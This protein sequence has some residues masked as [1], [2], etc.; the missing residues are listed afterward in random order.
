[1][2]AIGS[3]HLYKKQKEIGRNINIF[4]TG[5]KQFAHFRLLQSGVPEHIHYGPEWCPPDPDVYCFA[6]T[7][8]RNNHTHIHMINNILYIYIYIGGCPI[9][10]CNSQQT[11]LTLLNKA[12][13]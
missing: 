8:Q 13:N 7:I 1:M 2:L 10:T 11:I 9:T 12:F 5:C 6:D 3:L 4:T